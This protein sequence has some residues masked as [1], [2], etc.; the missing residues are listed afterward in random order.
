[1]KK[2]TSQTR[3]HSLKH[4]SPEISKI[5]K[6]FHWNL[7]TI[8]NLKCDYCYARAITSEWSKM[9]NNDTIPQVLNSL[10]KINGPK[11][12]FILGGEPTLHPKY[13]FV[14]E[15]L[16]NIG[17]EVLGNITNGMY[18]DY[19]KMV[20]SHLPF[21]DRFYWNITFHP[22]QVFLEKD[23]KQFKET[24][25]Y[26]KENNF[27]LNVNLL[28][29]TEYKE[30]INDMFEFCKENNIP[31]YPSFLFS[32]Q[33]KEFLPFDDIE[34]LKEINEKYTPPRELHYHTESGTDVFNDLD[35]YIND[36]NNFEGWEC[37]NNSFTIPVNQNTFLQMCSGKEFSIEDLNKGQ[38]KLICPLENCICPSRLGDEKFRITT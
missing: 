26:I 7:I 28:L 27:Y 30:Q 19:K 32:E 13:F 36:L 16:Y 18:K 5:T 20:T 38:C 24:L 22:S 6:R 10:Q 15:E 25:L 4:L 31:I 33:T 9:T 29:D 1:M 35:T 17:I 34:W 2:Y 14:L 37:I 21:K 12:V 8:C 23:V 11:E 3:L